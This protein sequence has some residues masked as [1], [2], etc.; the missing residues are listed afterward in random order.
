MVGLPLLAGMLATGVAWRTRN[1][2]LTII[3]GMAA[4]WILQFFS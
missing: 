4:L 3:M 2:L 1:L